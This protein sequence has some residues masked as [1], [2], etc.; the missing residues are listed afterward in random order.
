MGSVA[1]AFA[2]GIVIGLVQ[3]LSQLWFPLQ[4][5]YVAVFVVFL[6]VLYLRPQGLFG[7]VVRA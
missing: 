6:A 3:G 5:Q 2:G 4:L 7:R 1:G